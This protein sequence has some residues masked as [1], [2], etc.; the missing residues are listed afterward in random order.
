MH[1]AMQYTTVWYK[2]SEKRWDLFLS[3]G[4]VGGGIRSVSVKILP[5]EWWIF[6]FYSA[7]LSDSHCISIFLCHFSWFWCRASCSGANVIFPFLWKRSQLVKYRRSKNKIELRKKKERKRNRAM[8][9][10]CWVVFTSEHNDLLGMEV[11]S[12]FQFHALVPFFS[13]FRLFFSFSRFF[14]LRVSWLLTDR[15]SRPI[16][17]S[18]FV[19]KTSAGSSS[20][21][22]SGRLECYRLRSRSLLLFLLLFAL[23]ALLPSA[24]LWMWWCVHMLWR[25]QQPSSSFCR[26]SQCE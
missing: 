4:V 2:D 12:S 22:V 1:S 26:P 8:L 11:D 15:C 13:I 16:W 10:G 14:S 9:A 25:K 6:L 24:G 19:T 7:K 18:H 17:M 23:K 5:S 21:S 20:S 3:P